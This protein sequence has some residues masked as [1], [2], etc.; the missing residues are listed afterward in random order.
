LTGAF[1][2]DAIREEAMV[3]PWSNNVAYLIRR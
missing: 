2:R 1:G 3:R